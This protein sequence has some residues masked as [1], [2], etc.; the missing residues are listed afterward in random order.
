VVRDDSLDARKEAVS[1]R[2]E[3]LFKPRP[4][5]PNGMPLDYLSRDYVYFIQEGH[6]GPIKIGVAAEP[7]NRLTDLQCANPRPVRLICAVKGS[8]KLEKHLHRLLKDHRIR[9]EWFHPSIEVLEAISE[10]LKFSKLGATISEIEC[11]DFHEDLKARRARAAG[12]E[13]VGP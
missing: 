6:S 9:G 12:R 1:R 13:N 10:A 8:F 3:A 11:D 7:R 5:A 4:P 2:M